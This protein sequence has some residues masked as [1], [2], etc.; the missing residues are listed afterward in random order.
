M[1]RQIPSF[2]PSPSLLK[3][4]LVPLI[5]LV[6]SCLVLIVAMI[7]TSYFALLD[8]YQSYYSYYGDS[9]YGFPVSGTA[10][11]GTVSSTSYDEAEMVISEYKSIS[12]GENGA[13]AEN[14]SLA[15]AA[16]DGQV[17]A[18]GEEFS[19]LS[20]LGNIGSDNG[21]LDAPEV[22]GSATGEVTGGGV[23]QVSTALYIAALCANLEI[24][25]RY[26][27]A[28]TV[29]YAPLGLDAA[30][31]SGTNDLRFINTTDYPVTIK[32]S[33]NGQVV[34]V[35]FVGH[36]LE[37]GLVITV[38]STILGYYDASGNVKEFAGGD[39][40]SAGDT[41]CEVI[42]YRQYYRSNALELEE[43]LTVSTYLLGS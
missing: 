14:L 17:V 1:N 35:G 31:A 3:N 30:V 6:F 32:A 19:F 16:I 24:T 15:V 41:Y 22:E 2:K 34:K 39:S 42:T 33:A 21:Y 25:E 36:P 9:A 13:R 5:A 29:D 11:V 40:I 28:Q 7:S 38:T 27:Y 26:P 43:P 8:D 4:P 23:S 10:G 18:P 37:E 20:A 12:G